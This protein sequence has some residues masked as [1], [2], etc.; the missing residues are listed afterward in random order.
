[1]V[2]RVAFS[3]CLEHFDSTVYAII[4]NLCEIYLVHNLGGVV[5]DFHFKMD[6]TVGLR[7]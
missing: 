5:M 3:E 1:M 4:T 6:A 7:P 2:T